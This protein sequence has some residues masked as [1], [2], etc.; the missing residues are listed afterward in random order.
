MRLR[1]PDPTHIC[2]ASSAVASA[3]LAVAAL[4]AAPG[5]VCAQGTMGVEVRALERRSAELQRLHAEQRRSVARSMAHARMS[6]TMYASPPT[7]HRRR[8]L[9][10]SM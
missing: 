6:D 4:G 3:L 5:V 9:S 7:L 2:A 1:S 8:T 10:P